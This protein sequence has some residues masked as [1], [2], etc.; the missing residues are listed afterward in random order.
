MGS[1][2][3]IR[4]IYL[5]DFLLWAVRS[6]ISHS[7]SNY[8]LQIY[9]ILAVAAVRLLLAP[10]YY[11]AE[12]GDTNIAAN[13]D[14]NV[15]WLQRLKEVKATND[16]NKIEDVARQYLQFAK[17]KEIPFQRDQNRWSLIRVR[18]PLIPRMRRVKSLAPAQSLWIYFRVRLSCYR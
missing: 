10:I 16:Q 18:Y 6:T 4:S 17:E 2:I 11:K 1:N 8:K 14:E 13:Y 5:T 12:R 3:C 15:G 7:L 9:S